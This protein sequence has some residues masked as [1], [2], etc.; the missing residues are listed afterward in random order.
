MGAV[1]AARLRAAA[2]STARTLPKADNCRMS[3]SPIFLPRIAKTEFSGG[4]RM[5]G[6]PTPNHSRI[7]SPRFRRRSRLGVQSDPARSGARYDG[8]VAIDTKCHSI[9]LG[10]DR[11]DDRYRL[12]MWQIAFGD[13]AC[14]C[15][16]PVQDQA[17]I[18]AKRRA[19]CASSASLFERAA[20]NA[21]RL[22]SSW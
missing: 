3:P 17:G 21:P 20:D 5:C 14:I 15:E 13:G 10:Q 4:V 6:C 18:P 1:T 7:Q 8:C 11:G 2:T 22:A 9:V 19:T 12:P 16:S